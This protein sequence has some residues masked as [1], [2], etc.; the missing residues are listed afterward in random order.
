V[1]DDLGDPDSYRGWLGTRTLPV[2]DFASSA[3]QRDVYAGDDAVVRRWLRPPWSIDGWRLDVIHMLGEGPG[4]ERNASH[5]RAIRRAI[6]EERPDAYVLGRALLRSDRLAAGRPGGRCD[7]L[8]RLPAPDAR[9][10]GRASTSAASRCRSTRPSSRRGCVAA[11]ARIPFALALSQL[12][13]LGSHDVPALPDPGR[14]RH[15][16][17]GRRHARALRLPRRA[18]RVLRRRDRARGRRR[19]RLPPSVPVGPARWDQAL[20][21]TVRASR[22]CRRAPPLARGDLRTLLAEGDVHAF[23]RVLDGE[24]RDRG[25][26]SRRRG[27]SRRTACVG[28]GVDGPWTDAVSGEV[29]PSGGLL[30]CTL[31]PRSARTLVSDARWLASDGIDT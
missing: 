17:R 22:G 6:R 20:R 8:L 15:R 19:S 5:V 31:A 28:D 3:V 30:R 12:N 2:L 7:E 16:G 24:C 4:A 23:A 21:A 14:R 1:F 11:R 27:R 25:P 13:L 29:V 26:A 9:V 10:L 18:L